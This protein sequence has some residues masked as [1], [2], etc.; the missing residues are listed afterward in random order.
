MD[1]FVVLSQNREELENFIPPIR[2]FLLE[3]LKLNL[4]PRK[5]LI[6]TVASGVD[7]LGWIHFPNRRVLR[8]ATKRRF[9]RRIS[10]RPTHETI[11][12]YLGLLSHGNT[13]KV[14]GELLSRYPNEIA[15]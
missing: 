9:F 5:V 1:D 15:Q 11:S 6:K 2:D 10:G 12:S 8:T 13:R 14:R 4:R 7:F 3:K